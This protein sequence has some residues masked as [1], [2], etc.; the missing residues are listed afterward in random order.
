[1][2][3]MDS[4]KWT[5]HFRL[6]GVQ[7][8]AIAEAVRLVLAKHPRNFVISVG[9]LAAPVLI[10]ATRDLHRVRHWFEVDPTKGWVIECQVPEEQVA[11]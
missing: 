4:N 10:V 2:I 5:L 3:A 8:L 11:E 9:T 7:V 6:S 1:M